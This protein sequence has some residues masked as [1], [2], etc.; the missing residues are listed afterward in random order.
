MKNN[1]ELQET[2]QFNNIPSELKELSHFV[3]WKLEKRNGKTTKI[4]YTPTGAKAASDN[5]ETWTDYN[6]AIKTA[7]NNKFDGIGFVFTKDT[8]IVGIDIDNKGKDVVVNGKVVHPEVNKIVENFASYTEITQSG[9]GIHILVFGQKPGDKC[10]K[11]LKNKGIE[12]EMYDYGR[13]FVMTGETL[14]NLTTIKKK[15]K[16]LDKLYNFVFTDNKQQTTTNNKQQRTTDTTNNNDN[17]ESILSKLRNSKHATKI[18]EMLNGGLAGHGSPSERD[19]SLCNYIAYHTKDA[20]II[21]QI[22]RSHPVY[23]VNKWDKKHFSDGR[24]YGQKTIDE[25]ITG[26]S[27]QSN[28]QP[29]TTEEKLRECPFVRVGTDYFKL[30]EKP[31][32]FGINRQVLKRWK[33]EEIIQDHGKE[34]LKQVPKFDDFILRFDYKKHQKVIN[35]CYNLSEPM[36][37]TPEKGEI[38]WSHILMNHIFGDQLELGYRYMKLLYEHP[39]HIAP[40]LALVSKT[41]GTGKTTVINWMSMLFGSNSVVIGSGDIANSFNSQYANKHIIIVEETL[42]DKALSVEKLKSLSTAKQITVNEKFISQYTLPFYGKII[43]TS[44]KEDKF[45]K[46]DQ[47]ETRFF[48]RKLNKPQFKNHSILS[49]LEKEIPAFLYY[50][51]NEVPA[52]DFERD[53]FGFTPEELDNEYLQSLKHESKTYLYKE[54]EEKITE[55]FLNE[56]ENLEEIKATAGDIKDKFFYNNYQIQLPYIRHVLKDEFNKTTKQGMYHPFGNEE[57]RK[58]RYFTFYKNDFIDENEAEKVKSE[59][60]EDGIPF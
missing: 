35:G 3:L 10:K 47:E 16:E 1:S 32:T 44:N 39:H 45:V 26:V 2:Q 9:N 13:F 40:I 7:E 46:I 30:I 5:P 21:D 22:I 56:G 12:V 55:F 8:G 42:L 59:E 15:Q 14:G 19:L 33:K 48:V 49:D 53:R 11:V 25:A 29:Q 17:V 24:T 41:R 34:Y 20:N 58:G 51:E 18:D 57:K 36:A 50:L 38:K 27:N 37:Y 43:L 52:I 4:P 28:Q 60:I 54:L 23:R 6:T 31:D